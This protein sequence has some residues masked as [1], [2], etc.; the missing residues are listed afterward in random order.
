MTWLEQ[1]RELAAQEGVKNTLN[2][3]FSLTPDNSNG[4]ALLL[5]HGFGSSPNELRP[6][7]EAAQQQGY[8]VCAVRLPG[9]GTTPEDLSRRSWLE[10]SANI[11]AGFDYLSCELKLPTSVA[12][13]STGALLTLQLSLKR[14]PQRQIL[15]APFLKLRHW[16]APFAGPLSLFIPFQNRSLPQQEQPF[17]YQ[18]RSLKGVAQINRLRWHLAHKLQQITTPTLILT[19]SGDQTIAPGTA[20]EIYRRLG[21]VNKS[22]HSYGD[23][24]PHVLTSNHPQLHDVIQRSLSF[25]DQD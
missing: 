19:S 16:L 12:G 15:L 2:L 11:L 10:W 13:L 7:A 18:R 24:V 17:C 4:R 6:L 3:P 1:Q 20:H 21:A 5:I 23:D 25:L 22:I 14:S 8:N 9:H